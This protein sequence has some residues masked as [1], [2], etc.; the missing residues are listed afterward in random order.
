MFYY[1]VTNH[2]ARFMSKNLES[3]KRPE[4]VLHNFTQCELKKSL[5]ASWIIQKEKRIMK[6]KP[7]SEM[8]KKRNNKKNE[9]QS[10]RQE[11]FMHL[12]NK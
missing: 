7:W 9:I 11:L 8:T 6:I 1:E 12:P 4:M 5:I 10:L 2:F 3:V